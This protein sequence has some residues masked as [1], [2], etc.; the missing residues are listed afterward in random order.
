MVMLFSSH[1]HEHVLAA[2]RREKDKGRQSHFP[3]GHKLKV[4]L[5]ISIYK[6]LVRTYM[7]PPICKGGWEMSLGER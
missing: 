1:Y 5:I 2:K 3:R 7:A 6:L 4:K